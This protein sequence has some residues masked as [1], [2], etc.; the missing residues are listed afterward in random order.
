MTLYALLTYCVGI[1]IGGQ[2]YFV[3]RPPDGLLLFSALA[4]CQAVM[5]D[6]P[7]P[8]P[9]V[10]FSAN[11]GMKHI[12]VLKW[13]LKQSCSRIYFSDYA[14]TERLLFGKVTHSY[15]TTLPE[16]VMARSLCPYRDRCNLDVTTEKGS[17]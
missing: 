9:T 5:K 8:T 2:N 10:Q 11:G 7:M 1:C 3:D 13:K 15:T 12:A 14:Q 4:D 16:S 17:K 6:L